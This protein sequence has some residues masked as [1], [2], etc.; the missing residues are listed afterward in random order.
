MRRLFASTNF[1]S[2]VQRTISL[3]KIHRAAPTFSVCYEIMYSIVRTLQYC[4]LRYYVNM[5]LC[6]TLGML[7]EHAVAVESTVKLLLA[8]YGL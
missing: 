8:M 7:L 5:Y 1:K 3:T 4:C 2:R 6:P